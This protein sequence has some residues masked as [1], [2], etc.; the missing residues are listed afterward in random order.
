MEN[1]PITIE[2]NGQVINGHLSK[3]SG[4]ANASLWHLMID[5]YFRGQLFR[6]ENYGWQFY[7]NGKDEFKDLSELFGNY[8]IAWFD[9]NS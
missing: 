2:M 6:T 4:S 1:I 9:S 7:G 5:D 3:V 8:V